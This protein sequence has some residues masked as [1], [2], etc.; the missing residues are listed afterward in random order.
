MKHNNRIR[1]EDIDKKP[2]FNVPEGYFEGLPQTIQRKIHAGQAP[3]AP[4]WSMRFSYTIA[5]AVLVLV[6][7][8]GYFFRVGDTFT[9]A[10]PQTILAG[11]SDTEIVQY[12]AQMDINQA[13]IIETASR[14][15]LQMERVLLYDVDSRDIINAIDLQEVDDF[16]L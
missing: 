9:A 3:A 15:D 11:I 6:I 8:A 12:L 14:V 10:D 1:L 7:I 2:V 4:E 13:D 16:D 5:A